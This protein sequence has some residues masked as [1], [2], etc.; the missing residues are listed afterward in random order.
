M[1][2]AVSQVAVPPVPDEGAEDT[3]G[4]ALF[5]V[6]CGRPVEGHAWRARRRRSR[7][8]TS[9][10]TIVAVTTATVASHTTRIVAVGTTGVSPRRM[11]SSA[12]R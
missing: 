12:R 10:T 2:V 1:G 4:H 11:A 7:Q 9:S 3:G 6:L 5:L 8:A